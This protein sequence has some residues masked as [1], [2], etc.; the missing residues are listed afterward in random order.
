MCGIVGYLGSRKAAE[1]IV[2]GLSKL[3]YRG[4][5]SAGV[6]VNSSN[7]EELNIRKFKGRLS[8]LAEDLEKN[9]IDGNLGIG[10]TRWA[11][12]GEPSDVNSHPHFNQA[13]TIAV[14]HNGIIENYMEIK[15]ELISEGV[16]FESQTDTEVI[17]HLV[18]KYYEGNLLDAVYKTI[19]KLRG[20]YALGVICKEH[21][22]EL[23]AVRKDSP[24][25]VGVGE[26][27]N[28]IASDIPALLKYTRD[29]YFLENGE[30]V[31]L[32][33][34]NVTVY[35]SNRNLVEKEVFHVTWDVEA[36]SKGGYDYFMSKE[37]H[38][39]PT[40]VRETLE[41]RLDDNGNI[42]LDSINISKEDLEKINKVYIVACGTAY[43]AGL[44]GKYAIEKFVNI[45]VITDIA[46][47]FR[48]SDP[49][50]DENSLVILVSQSGE[51][52]DTLAVLRDS[53]A[54]GARILSITN[55]VGSSIARES[56]D[57]F[58]T[59]AGPEV[60]VAS[61]KAYT[62]QIT[63]LYMIALDF[64]IKKGTITREF[65]DSMIS[66]MKEIPSKI[67]EILDNEEYI[68]EVAKTVVSSEH[69][70]YLGRGIDYSLAMEGSLKLKEI[71]YI[72][73]E[74]F[75]AGELKHGTIALIEKGTPVIAIA[76]QEKLFEKMV[77]NM[78]E[79]RAR[80]AYVVAIAQSHNK[81]VEKAADKII[82]IPNSDDI[83]SPILAVVPM[84]LLAY[85]V[86]VLRGCDVD[87]PRNLAK[88]VTVE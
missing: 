19:S 54:K 2:E 31:H 87:K 72:H 9:P 20:A 36:A 48:Y 10:H 21:G 70:F 60:A 78:E 11:T 79:V 43:N 62:T 4:Y 30:V 77:S 33:D 7:E 18:D 55:I 71:S 63:S 68:K 82:Y 6:A 41:R 42:V 74:A 15:E 34:E 5:D 13:K 59:W 81:D 40:G 83:L 45:P 58:Y 17:A 76:T 44:L 26:G 65:Y 56:D 47:E 61:T 14:V 88:S 32:K 37:I 75:A 51:T 35:D 8:V 3:E 86:S 69:A 12:H 1:V 53:K 46:S 23:V 67:Q 84:Q 27:E 80:G 16:K 49:F 29:V 28:F 39:Q 38:E 24:L 50:V 64:A 25:V 22:N 66:K 85:H 73:A 57:V 52:A